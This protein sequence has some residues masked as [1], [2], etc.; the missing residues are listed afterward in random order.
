MSRQV[1]HNQ[2][3]EMAHGQDQIFGLFIQIF[4][5]IRANDDDEG[6]L[7]NLDQKFDGLTQDKMLEIAERYGFYKIV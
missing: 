2:K 1:Q 7:V 4:E 6:L 5:H 3:Y